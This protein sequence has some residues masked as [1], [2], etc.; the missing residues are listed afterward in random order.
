VI[1]ADGSEARAERLER[2]LN[3]DP[4]IGVARHALAGYEIALETAAR[5]SIKLP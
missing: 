5:E 3:V 2:V 1:V 4:G